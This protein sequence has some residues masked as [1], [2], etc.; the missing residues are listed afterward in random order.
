MESEGEGLKDTVLYGD[1][2]K[3]SAG[4]QE[5]EGEGEGDSVKDSAGSQETEGEG[6]EEKESAT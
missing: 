4:S 6:E 3:I 2:V 1:S 5:T